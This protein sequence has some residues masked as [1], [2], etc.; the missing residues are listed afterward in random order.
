MIEL[1]DTSVWALARRDA[2]IAEELTEALFAH[3]VATCDPVR[4]EVLCTAREIGEFRQ[5]RQ[6]LASLHHCPIDQDVWD[7]ALDVYE[8]LAAQGGAHQRQVSH[9]DLL[10]AAAA[11]AA[12]VPVVHYDEDYDRIAAVTGQATRWVRA[13]GT[14]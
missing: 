3:R 13:R 6:S 2:T 1:L 7:R 5:T 10:I 8:L 14:F 11:E 12:D 9:P 4:L